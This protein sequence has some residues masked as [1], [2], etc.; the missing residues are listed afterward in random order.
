MGIRKSIQ[1]TQHIT[2]IQLA[3]HFSVHKSIGN[4]LSLAMLRW[5]DH[6]ARMA[7]D[8]YQKEFYLDG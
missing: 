1:W 6:V 4:L 2:T 3:E 7:D 8:T 5:L